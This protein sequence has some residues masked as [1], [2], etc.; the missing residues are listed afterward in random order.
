V[1]TLNNKI[2]T[3]NNRLIQTPSAGYCSQFQTIYDTWIVKPSDAIAGYYNTMVKTI[4]DAGIWAKGDVFDF[5]STHSN[6]NLE[7]Y[8]NWINPLGACNPAPINSPVWTQYEGTIGNALSVRYVRLNFTPNVNGVNY[9]LDDCCIIEGCAT[10]AN[11]SYDV[12]VS[13][14][15]NLALLRSWGGTSFYGALNAAAASTVTSIQTAG[16]FGITR[17][18][19]TKQNLWQNLALTANITRLSVALPTK[20]MYACGFNNNGT[21]NGCAKQLRYVWIGAYLDAT[22]YAILINAIETCLDALGTGLIV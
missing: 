16:H 19:S 20:E 3:I 18:L 9:K 6:N 4:V 1:L 22:Q 17:I 14:G 15:A 21:A 8:Y 13:D 11:T 7:A 5:F 2:L 10:A 12:G